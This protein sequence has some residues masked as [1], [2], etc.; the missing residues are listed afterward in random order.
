[1]VLPDAARA[2]LQKPLVVR[3][4]VTDPDGYPH[5]VPVWF[6]LDGDDIMIF[7]YRNTRKI[8]YL[9][10]NPKGSVQIGGES[11]VDGFLLKGNYSLEDDPE[12]Q[13][14]WKI[15]RLYEN[16]EL[17]KQHMAEWSQQ[18]LFLVRLVVNKVIKV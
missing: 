14:A 18:D 9:Q 16:E 10:A 12:H 2:V 4:A 1:M 13:W 7:G 3:M 6:G 17:A 15:T 8:S 11:G 5:V